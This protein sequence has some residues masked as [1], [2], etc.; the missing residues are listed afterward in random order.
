MWKQE[1]A[2]LLFERLQRAVGRET[3]ERTVRRLPEDL[4]L[5]AVGDIHGH[6]DLLESL[7]EMIR[8][9]AAA[10]ACERRRVVY[11]GDYIDR[12]PASR[13]VIDTLIAQ[14]LEGF[15]AVHL[16][17][18][19]EQFLCRFLRDPDIGDTWLFN[20]GEATLHSY[21]LDPRQAPPRGEDRL[22]WLARRLGEVLP[23]AHRAFLDRLQLRHETGDYLFVHA[24]V[25][26]GI[27]LERQRAEDLIWIREPFL[28]SNEEFGRLVVHGHTPGM[29]PVER[30]NRIC[31]DTGAC[32][33]GQLTALVLQG[34]QRA[35][36]R[37]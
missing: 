1:V 12:G 4:R 15:E 30:E 34:E 16:L 9:D 10:H 31:I 32:Y 14:P 11:L 36:L 24:G 6:L 22:D 37:A 2:R 5:Y 28:G 13:Q 20:G 33:G 19:H 27:P 7:H 17:G 25:R 35:F 18:N 26:P 23:A 8:A 21:G 3:A 29:E